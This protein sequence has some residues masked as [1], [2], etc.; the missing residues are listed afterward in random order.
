M[1]PGY[2][3]CQLCGYLSPGFDRSKQRMHFHDEHPMEQ[4]INCSKYVLRTKNSAPKAGQSQDQGFDPLKYLGMIMKCPKEDC[5]FENTSNATMN[6]HLRK[7][8]Q[9][10][11]CG[12]CGKTHPN[13]SEFHRHSA[14][15]HGDK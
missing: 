2:L 9:T 12:H 7:H 15:I 14:M 5:T 13:S 1:I 6:A 10:F 8:T 4:N 3:E 11:K